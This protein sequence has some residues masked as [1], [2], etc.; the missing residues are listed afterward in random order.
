MDFQGPQAA[1]LAD[2]YALNAAFLACFH[3]PG[4]TAGLLLRRTS[5]ALVERLAA[6]DAQQLARLARAPFL[7]L[8][9]REYDDECW[10]GLFRR[11]VGHD[12]LTPLEQ[13]SDDI[14]RLTAAG[15]GFLWQLSKRNPYTA[16]LV[17]GAT[18]YW[19][20]RVAARTLMELLLRVIPCNHLLE[21]RLADNADFW[22]KLL[23]A[24]VNSEREVRVAARLC[25]LQTMLTQTPAARYRSLPAAACNMP[26]PALRVADKS[27]SSCGAKEL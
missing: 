15:M 11:D 14:A 27:V 25:A 13:P 21:P 26:M 12:L 16:R 23:S 8:S 7:L 6:L 4:T 22:N 10:D 24:G 5:P 17:S 18:L 9:F 2:V 20:E 3:A 1:D 19:C